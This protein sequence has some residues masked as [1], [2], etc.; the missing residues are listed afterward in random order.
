MNDLHYRILDISKKHKLAHLGSCLTAVD[1]I[2]GIYKEKREEEKFVLSSGHAGLALYVVLEK[3]YGFDAEDLYL[4][5]GMHPYRNEEDKIYCST[6]SLGI[7]LLVAIGM[8]LSDRSK[9]VFC[10]ISDG[11]CYEGAVWEAANVIDRYDIKNLRLFLNFNRYSAY[12]HVEDGVIDKIKCILPSVSVV[13]TNVE[14]YGLTGLS[15][16]YV[17]L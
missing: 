8:A 13:N 17:T 4:R 2:D 7:G 5:H 11:E 15:A 16:H 12:S 10:L 6:G 9:N 1:I 3:Y 14:D